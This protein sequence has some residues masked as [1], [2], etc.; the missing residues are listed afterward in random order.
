MHGFIA[1][2]V[3]GFLIFFL[4]CGMIFSWFVYRIAIDSDRYGNWL[5]F[6]TI[7]QRAIIRERIGEGAEFSI[8]ADQS[9]FQS[10]SQKI[11]D[12][13]LFQS[14]RSADCD[15]SIQL[16]GL[17]SNFI[18]GVIGIQLS[19]VPFR[20]L[21]VFSGAA[22]DVSEYLDPILAQDL[23]S[24]IQGNGI[25]PVGVLGD[26]REDFRHIHL[27][28]NASQLTWRSRECGAFSFIEFTGVQNNG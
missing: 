12:L 2:I 9:T 20:Y 13:H 4:A 17:N 25:G 27:L 28:L 6:D 3:T 21:V 22:P 11:D 15:L 19:R 18:P 26:F 14:G 7:V 10:L 24:P 8:L 5:I 16:D 1:K 23:L